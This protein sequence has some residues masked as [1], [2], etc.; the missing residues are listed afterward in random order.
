MPPFLYLSFKSNNRQDCFIHQSL[1]LLSGIIRLVL[2]LLPCGVRNL[3]LL[4]DLNALDDHMSV[5]TEAASHQFFISSW[6]PT[7]NEC[8]DGPRSQLIPSSCWAGATG[9]LRQLKAAAAGLDF[10][11]KAAPEP[12][13]QQAKLQTKPQQH[14]AEDERREQQPGLRGPRVRG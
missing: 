6:S 8:C 10:S 14:E 13:L 1:E 11:A 12:Q 5:S 7:M 9:Q 3:V 2:D 4:L